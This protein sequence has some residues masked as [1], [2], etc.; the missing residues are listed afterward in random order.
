MTARCVEDYAHVGLPTDCAAI[1]LMETDGH[2]AAVAEEAARMDAIAREHG[3]REVRAARDEAEAATL[4]AARRSAFS[5]LARQRPT[6]ILEDVTVPR[7]ALAAMVSFIADAAATHGLQIGTFGHMGDGNLHPTFLTDER[8]AVEMARVHQAFDAIVTR[9]LELGGTITGEH[10]VG[11]AK[12]AWLR[13]QMGD[14]SYDLMRQIKRAID[15]RDLLNP[16]K[17]FE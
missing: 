1:L 16:G 14:D 12:K 17:I 7:T 9:T 3:A 13:R 6:T 4:A 8:D 15:P 11:L 5:A 2:P 10:G